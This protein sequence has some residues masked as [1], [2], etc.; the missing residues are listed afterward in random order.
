[1]ILFLIGF[2]GSVFAIPE[3]SQEER[4][5]GADVIAI[6]QILSY[7]DEG[8]YRFYEITILKE[9][10]NSASSETITMRS[11]NEDGFD[12]IDPY[13][14]FEEQDLVLLYLKDYG[15]GFWESTNFSKKVDSIDSITMPWLKCAQNICIINTW[16]G[17]IQLNPGDQYKLDV[18]IEPEKKLHVKIFD[19]TD[20]AVLDKIFTPDSEGMVYAIY[21]IPDK[22]DSLSFYRVAISLVDSNQD[23]KIGL[24][25]RVGEPDIQSMLSGYAATADNIKEYGIF[26]VGEPIT[27]QSHQS[28]WST[29]V[30]PYLNVNLEFYD[31][32]R[33]LL[34]KAVL[35]NDEKGMSSYTFTPDKSGYYEVRLDAEHLPG[36]YY[37]RVILFPVDVK[38]EFTIFEEGE[39]FVISFDDYATSKF[40]IK[41][42]EFSK[43]EK[44]LS[45]MLE[46]P[47]PIVNGMDVLVPHKLLDGGYTVFVDGEQLDYD[48][49]VNSQNKVYVNNFEG[50]A[51]IGYNI[52]GKRTHQVDIYGTTAIPEFKTIAMI[53]AVSILPIIFVS[54]RKRK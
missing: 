38:T 12:P 7:Y 13:N 26:T 16:K 24:I 35:Q 47:F 3:F 11:I 25:F 28:R 5:H 14:V 51:D 31:E 44:R 20:T 48:A 32:D 54:R 19:Y 52:V 21:D 17:N 22:E 10:K 30:P 41:D 8:K 40:L 18:L 46:H 2:I 45:I 23:D 6:G 9:L 4:E 34:D 49:P 1:M 53:L 27:I 37:D 50:Y 42:V 36:K 39:E 15:R 43:E 29:P 33:N